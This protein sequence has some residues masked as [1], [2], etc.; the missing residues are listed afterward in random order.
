MVL[1]S[2]AQWRGVVRARRVIGFADVR[3]ESA[4]ESV[5]RV[6]FAQFK[7][8]APALQAN[9]SGTQGFIGRQTSAGTN[10]GRSGRRTAR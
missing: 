10:T 9:I 4:L 1:E 8:P 6:R 7:I 2:C 3:A 5:A